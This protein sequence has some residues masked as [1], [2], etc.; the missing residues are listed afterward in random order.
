MLEGK[1]PGIFS[2]IS[3][4]EP[5]QVA[6]CVISVI[7]THKAIKLC[8]QVLVLLFK[9]EYCFLLLLTPSWEISN[10]KDLAK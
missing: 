3:D 2:G 10:P 7:D 8:T 9:K 4:T 6:P 5:V 1:F